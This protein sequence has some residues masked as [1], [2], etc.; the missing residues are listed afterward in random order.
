MET[1]FDPQETEHID[2][3]LDDYL[4]EIKLAADKFE[5]WFQPVYEIVSGTVLHNEVLVRWRDNEGRLRSPRELFEVLQN[6]HL[7]G[8]LDRIVVEKSIEILAQNSKVSLSINLSAEIL[9]DSDFLSQL[10]KW[11]EH[12]RVNPKLLMFELDE[13]IFIHTSIKSLEL[14]KAF[15]QMGCGVVLDSFTGNHFSLHQW[16][17]LPIDTIKLD[18]NLIADPQSSE[19]KQL[20]K[21]IAHISPIF[22]KRCIATGI[23]NKQIL[24]FAYDIGVQGVQGFLLGRPD[25]KPKTFVSVGVLIVRII[26]F[27]ILLYI[28]KSLAGIDL[29]PNRHAWEVIADFFQSL[30]EGT[31]Q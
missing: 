12:Y 17:S 6:T 19:Q 16:Q 7:M 9:E 2:L 28:I 8:Q 18:R 5:L 22:H 20:A 11:L 13:A 26:T 21:A 31:K 24:K 1:E 15:K 27:L 10:Q 14:M 23:D 25:D 29:F 4:S 3:D 30:F